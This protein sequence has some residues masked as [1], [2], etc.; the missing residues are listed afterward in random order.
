MS[1]TLEFDPHSWYMGFAINDTADMKYPGKV[2]RI[3]ANRWHAYTDN[4]STY[5]VD[6]VV[7]DTLADLKQAIRAYHVRQHNGYGERIL[8]RGGIK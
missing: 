4:G 7:A 6:E 2:Y 1:L 3:D 5:Y 8:A